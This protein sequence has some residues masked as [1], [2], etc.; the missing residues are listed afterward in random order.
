MDHGTDGPKPDGGSA[1]SHI[2]DCTTNGSF[3]LVVIVVD[4]NG[5]R[6]DP[7]IVHVH[8]EP[9]DIPKGGGKWAT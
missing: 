9:K 7:G 4:C 5:V 2:V 3:D 1:D 8:Y 6:N